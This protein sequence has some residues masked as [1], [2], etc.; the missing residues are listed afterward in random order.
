[1]T[2]TVNS[3]LLGGAQISEMSLARDRPCR[4]NSTRADESIRDARTF[5]ITVSE[6][7]FAR[8]SQLAVGALSQLV[9]VRTGGGGIGE[10]RAKLRSPL[11]PVNSPYTGGAD[12]RQRAIDH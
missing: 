3:C 4:R 7:R 8:L 11:D 6:G 10:A 9:S 12:T 2:E 5:A 1:M